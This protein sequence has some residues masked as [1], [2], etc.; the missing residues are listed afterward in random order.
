[1]SVYIF[2][3]VYVVIFLAWAAVPCV[4]SSCVLISVCDLYCGRPFST[5][6]LGANLMPI[7]IS[8]SSVCV[9]ARCERSAEGIR[10]PAFYRPSVLLCVS[11]VERGS[12]RGGRPGFPCAG[13]RNT[14]KSSWQIK[15]TLE[16]ET[17]EIDGRE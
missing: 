10:Q 16:E 15:G 11:F 8:G 9:R 14:E 12:Q 5:S 6:G 2:Q 17:R 4:G 3:H 1:M 7:N 13:I